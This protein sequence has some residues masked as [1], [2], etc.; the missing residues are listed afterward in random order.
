MK[1]IKNDEVKIVKGKD[2]GKKGKIEKVFSKTDLVLIPGIN[3]YKR[4]MKARTQN[5]KSQIITITKPMHAENVALICPKCKKQ[6]RVG[7]KMDVKTGKKVRFC[8][9]CNKEI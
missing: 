6:T 8:K 5:E 9:K 7:Y 2:K 4:H 3:E 1:L